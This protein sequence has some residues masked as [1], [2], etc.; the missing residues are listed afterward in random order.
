MSFL[1]HLDELRSRLFKALVALGLAFA[2]AW[3]QSERL[4]HFMVEPLTPFLGGRK[5]VFLEITEPF[6]LYMKVALLAA[7][8]AAAPVIL[9]QAWAFVAPGLYPRERRHAAPFIAVA[10]VLFVAGGAFGYKVA[11]PYAARFLLSI[12]GDFEPALTVK[13]LFGF[14][15]KIILG[16]GLVFEMPAVIYLLASLGLVT[17]TFLLHHLKMAVLISFIVAAIIT[18]TPDM[19]TQ[20]VFALPMVGL[21][22]L[23]IGASYLVPR[24][25][26]R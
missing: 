20:C 16:M 24:R 9:Y 25:D 10:S 23:G 26:E 11:F 19:V 14:E 22:L 2:L 12:A 17:P 21:Y 8:F 5:L 15:S 7:A 4:F 6:M 13:S 18:P 3:S 1:E